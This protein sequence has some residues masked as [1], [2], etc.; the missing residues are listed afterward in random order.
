M[1][2]IQEV[3]FHQG[4]ASNYELQSALPAL[5]NREESVHLNLQQFGEAFECK[6]LVNVSRRP[7]YRS[8]ILRGHARPGRFILLF[9]KIVKSL[10]AKHRMIYES[11]QNAESVDN[12]TP[13]RA[14]LSAGRGQ[15]SVRALFTDNKKI[16]QSRLDEL[17]ADVIVE[18][19]LPFRFVESD[20]FRSLVDSLIPSDCS[21][22]CEKTLR[23]RIKN[24]LKLMKTKLKTEF[25]SVT[26]VC[27]TADSWKARGKYVCL[28]FY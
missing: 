24:K 28:V 16:T 13:K 11:D 26:A 4:K 12:P 9:P 8:A 17:V 6:S 25:E 2:G 20:S 19:R 14:R 5:Q 7:Y 10:Q 1:A 3:F 23:E 18:N 21:L 15:T 22:F 27:T